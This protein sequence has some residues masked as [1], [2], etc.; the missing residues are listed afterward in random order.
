MMMGRKKIMT[1]I[2]LSKRYYRSLIEEWKGIGI[3]DK[4]AEDCE[5]RHSASDQKGSLLHFG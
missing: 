2:I 5:K 4:E 3:G 1:M